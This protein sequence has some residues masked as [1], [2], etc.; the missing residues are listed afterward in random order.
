[1]KT[2]A[3]MAAETIPYVMSQEVRLSLERFAEEWTKKWLRENPEFTRRVLDEATRIF[4][5]SIREMSGAR[6]RTRRRRGRRPRS[7]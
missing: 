2:V 7:R 1:M 3:E 6:P 4:H 5:D